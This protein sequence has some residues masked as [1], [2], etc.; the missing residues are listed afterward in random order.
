MRYKAIRV[1]RK[2][3]RALY[4]NV[5]QLARAEM[6]IFAG[7]WIELELDDENK[8]LTMRMVHA[9]EEQPLVSFN[10]ADMVPATAATIP[11]PPKGRGPA[12]TPLLE[13]IAS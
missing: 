12:T 6:R 5:P 7:D 10:R 4:L 8:T 2:V 9:R 11:D 1:I 13:P 3:G